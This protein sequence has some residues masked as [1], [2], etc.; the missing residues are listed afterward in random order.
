MKLVYMILTFNRFSLYSLA[1]Y[2]L[3]NVLLYFTIQLL[4]DFVNFLPVYSFVLS[5]FTTMLAYPQ[6]AYMAYNYS[7]YVK[8]LTL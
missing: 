2:F 4:G 5:I 1:S 8:C 7:H 3:I 6:L